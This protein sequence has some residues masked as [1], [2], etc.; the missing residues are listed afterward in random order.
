MKVFRKSTVAWAALAH[1]VVFFVLYLLLPEKYFQ[2]AGYALVLGAG[3][4]ALW[5]WFKDFVINFREGKTGAN[6]L[7][8]GTY[9]LIL[10]VFLHRV[11]VVGSTTFPNF[12]LFSDDMLIRIAVWCLGGGLLLLFFAPDVG[13]E[14]LPSKSYVTLGIGIALGSF[15]MGFSVAMGI[16]QTNIVP[17]VGE[18]DSPIC[19]ENRQI[20]GSSSKVFHTL[21]SPYRSM[22]KPEKCFKS[23]DEAK[24]KGYRPPMQ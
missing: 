5:R 4:A 15:M 20:L 7:V 24:R 8:V 13:G 23:V 3:I 10:F 1:M 16:T 2:Y 17:A 9:F 6:F 12:W 11:V 14:K 21:D 22:V 18:T 19:P